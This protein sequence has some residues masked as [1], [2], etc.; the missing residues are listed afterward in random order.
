M[1]S[2]SGEPCGPGHAINLLY[3][4]LL[5]Q[6]KSKGNLRHFIG[7]DRLSLLRTSINGV[8]SKPLWDVQREALMRA[9]IG[10]S[11]CIM[12]MAGP[13]AAQTHVDGYFRNNGTYVAPHYRSSP[14]S[15]RTNNYSTYG[16]V[17][18]YTG[19]VGTVPLQPQYQSPPAYQY[20]PP[21]P[22]YQAPPAYTPPSTYNPYVLPKAY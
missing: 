11:M 17:N 6:E 16:N 9:S 7:V 19:N 15:S 20:R 5:R 21:S 13:A 22:T 3:A 18:P 10:F 1:G 2:G 4:A 14:D 8:G 12:V